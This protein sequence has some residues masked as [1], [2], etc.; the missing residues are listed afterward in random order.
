[1]IAIRVNGTEQSVDAE[2]RRT[3]LDALRHNLGLTGAKKAC[4]MGN[5]G[6]CT[7]QL[8]GRAVYSCLVLAVDCAGQE[9]TTIEGLADGDLHPLQRAFIEADA[10]Q[11]GY[12]TPG[13]IMSLKAL[14]DR[15]PQPSDAEIERA[16]SGNLCR[17]GAYQH[18][19]AAARMVRDGKK[20]GDS[21]HLR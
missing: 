6:A 12:C 5:C 17:C 7:V 4:D 9:V 10:F 13:Q 19:G 11:C 20:N 3:L 15:S 21:H 2:P 16:L 18:I 1:M 8:D 14:F